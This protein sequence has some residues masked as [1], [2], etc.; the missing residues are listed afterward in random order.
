MTYA[1]FHGS[2]NSVWDTLDWKKQKY[3]QNLKEEYF[4][5][6][7]EN[8]STLKEIVSFLYELNL[9]FQR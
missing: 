8:N 7:N 3:I 5:V 1:A 4:E 6:G 9:I 2:R